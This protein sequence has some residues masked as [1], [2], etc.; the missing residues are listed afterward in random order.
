[1]TGAQG[2]VGATG[3]AGP[4]GP[5]GPTG[6]TGAAGSDALWTVN[7]TAMY[8]DGGSVGVG[9]NDPKT[10]FA[11]KGNG[12]T[13]PVG[14]TQNQVGGTS[15]M[16]FTTLDDNDVQ[17]T[18]LLL[19][20]GNNDSDV[21]FYTGARGAEEITVFVEG[22]NGNV[23]IGIKDPQQPLDVDGMIRSRAGGVEF[24]DGSI[25]DSATYGP[26]VAATGRLMAGKYE[27]ATR[28]LLVDTAFSSTGG[29]TVG[30]NDQWQSFTAATS[31]T[32]AAID[33]ARFDTGENALMR[34][35][36]GTGTDGTL[37]ASA[38]VPPRT[39]TSTWEWTT[40][41]FAEELGIVAGNVYTIRLTG[42]PDVGGD[43]SWAMGSGNSYAGG[44]S[45]V[46][47]DWDC[48]FR[49]WTFDP[50]DDGE[51][52][53]A[54]VIEPNTGHV[55]ID[56]TNPNHPLHMGSGAHVTAGGVWT[57]ASSRTLK[58]NFVPVDARSVLQQ[59]RALQ[60]TRWNY[61]TED[62][63]VVHLGPMAEDFFEAFGLG[64]SAVSIGTIDANGVALA[65]IQA[66]ATENA[67]LKTDLERTA[68]E[69]AE[70][71]EAVR[72]LAARSE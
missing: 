7:G 40:G 55:G 18:R 60:L 17:A 45:G 16:E 70:L 52:D 4:Q 63:G 38:V 64:A 25:Q 8:Y 41:A 9:L 6:A 66:L 71:R 48:Y 43:V 20:G 42:N 62:D 35:Y 3:D 56:R 51:L 53:P 50:A 24:P 47:P 11:L 46:Q 59:V 29:F 19:R 21:E 34:V 15:T 44:Q 1:M 2:P 67:E 54:L 13:N 72:S 30:N 33:V 5:A 12:G 68:A 39:S 14:I 26:P 31:S 23:G 27:I 10:P 22:S 58:E 37:L 32:V 36:E 69:L 28:P 49:V 61:R 65:S 57:N